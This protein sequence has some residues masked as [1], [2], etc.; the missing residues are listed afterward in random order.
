MNYLGKN[1]WP[2]ED[3]EKLRELAKS[4]ESATEIAKHMDRSVDS[5]RTRASR[6]NIALAK[7]RKLKARISK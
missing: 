5:V 1:P 6:L 4:G 2:P 3:D 7:S